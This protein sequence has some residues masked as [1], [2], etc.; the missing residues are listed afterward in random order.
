MSTDYDSLDRRLK[1]IENRG[2]FTSQGFQKCIN[3]RLRLIFQKLKAIE[4]G[5]KDSKNRVPIENKNQEYSIN[6]INSVNNKRDWST[7]TNERNKVNIN[8]ANDSRALSN[9][10]TLLFRMKK[11]DNF[12]RFYFLYL[13]FLYALNYI[14]TLDNENLNL[15]VKYIKN[16]N[17]N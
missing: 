3:Q 15:R 13:N 17:L 9:N 7:S 14:I 12:E 16:L 10:E 6:E 5:L 8:K 11:N 4:I 2:H 1:A